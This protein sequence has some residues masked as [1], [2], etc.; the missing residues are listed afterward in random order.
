MKETI[1]YLLII[2][3]TFTSPFSLFAQNEKIDSL[4]YQITENSPDSFKVSIY[5]QIGKAYRNISPDTSLYYLELGLNLARKK[6]LQ[7]AAAYIMCDIG[8][9]YSSVKGAYADGKKWF[10]QSLEIGEKLND[11]KILDKAN[12]GLG[13]IHND[14]RQYEQAIKYYQKSHAWALKAN[15]TNGGALSLNAI[16]VIHF[17]L[18]QFDKAIKYFEEARLRHHKSNEKIDEGYALVN[19]GAA[20]LMQEGKIEQAL[21]NIHATMKLISIEEKPSLISLCYVNLADA[22]YK[23]KDH[24]KALWAVGES[25]AIYEKYQHGDYFDSMLYQ[26]CLSLKG[27]KNYKVGI[28]TAKQGLKFVE[29]KGVR[30]GKLRFYEILSQLYEADENFK[31]ALITERKYTTLNDSLNQLEIEQNIEQL[32]IR[33]Q[34]KRK[35]AE[36]ALL[37]EEKKNQALVI[38]RRNNAILGILVVLF[39]ASIIL[40]QMYLARNKSKNLNEQLEKK[41][42]QRTI[43]LELLNKE[44]LQSNKEL[45]RFN[46]IASH[47]LKEPVRIIGNFTGLIKR[48]IANKEYKDLETYINFVEKS[49]IQLKSKN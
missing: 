31:E 36:N 13:Y 44:L 22:Y 37:K 11:A 8:Y 41:I 7:E 34:T 21:D 5:R 29:E 2:F 9:M 28:R 40:Y 26:R 46:Y 39:L 3:T 45:E 42:K 17:N 38:Q 14:M 48:C 6:N 16:G 25:I 33:F 32:D 30:G 49:T 15:Q 20:Y 4:H 12:Y 35:E 1:K 47:D 19:I 23:L 24:K 27:L 18:M 10:D 43:K